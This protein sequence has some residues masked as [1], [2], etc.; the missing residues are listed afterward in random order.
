MRL[1]KKQIEYCDECPYHFVQEGSR[2]ICIHPEGSVITLRLSQIT[3]K[4]KGV[5]DTDMEVCGYEIP[6]QCPL[7]ILKENQ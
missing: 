5:N 2:H 4:G 6:K 1:L 3:L 7:P